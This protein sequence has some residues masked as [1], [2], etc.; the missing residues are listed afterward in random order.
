M[1]TARVYYSRQAVFAI[2]H[3]ASLLFALSPFD[4]WPL[5]FCAPLFLL[6][7]A[8]EQ[9]DKGTRQIL[10]GALLFSFATTAITFGWI[11]ATIWRYSAQNA[12]LSLALSVLYAV[13]FQLKFPLVF[14]ML[15]AGRL[16][17]RQHAFAPL[18]V[19]AA[20][21]LGDAL[22]PE[23]FPWSWGNGIAAQA[24]LRQ[25]A[26]V[27]SVYLMS[28]FAARAAS[29]FL[30]LWFK[31]REAFFAVVRAQRWSLT[32]LAA[33]L[34]GA[35]V[36]RDIPAAESQVQPLRVAIVQTNIGAAASGKSSDADFAS[37]AINRLFG[38]SAE[39]LQLYAPVDLMLWPEA[40]MPFHSAAPDAANRDIYSVTF[41]GAVE[42]LRRRAGVAV[43]F[44]DMYKERSV[45]R[46]RLSARG[47]GGQLGRDYFKRRLVPWGEYL[48]FGSRRWFPEAGQFTAA[49]GSETEIDLALAERGGALRYGQL[50]AEVALVQQPQILRQRF[51]PPA[52]QRTLRIKPLLCYEALYPADARTGTA[53]VIVNLAS[54]AWF[55]DGIEGAQHASATMLRA[56]ENGRPMLRAAM[57][58]ISFAVDYKGDDLAPR[59]GQG[60]PELLFAEVALATRKT[61]FARLGMVVFYALM[62]AALW[63][64]IFYRLMLSNTEEN[65]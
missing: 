20:L 53:D 19:A 8:D 25:L 7:A 52:A 45:L 44:H 64:L 54:D 6:L 60:R 48:P 35:I 30:Y 9:R 55:G 41:D 46:S 28:F 61:P 59:T 56:V 24:H 16:T 10:L 13:I 14:V 50:A 58:G 32:V 42:Y 11:F 31:R 40:A 38:Q 47:A 33:T 5:G 49:A 26:A 51:E 63:P 62:L 34:A 3:A 17:L 1:V 22:A 57:S 39:A 2:A 43:L 65:K 15:R 23:L 27:G 4:C 18:A 29:V 36:Y 37:E 21:A 12:V